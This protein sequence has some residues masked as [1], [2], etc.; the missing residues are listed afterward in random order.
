[1][2]DIGSQL[3]S[4]WARYGPE[5]KINVTDDFTR[6]TLDSIA[7]YASYFMQIIPHIHSANKVGQQMFYGYQVQLV[8]PRRFASICCG[9]AGILICTCYCPRSISNLIYQFFL[10]E[11]G[12][13]AQRP[14]FVSDYLY[15]QSTKKYW[16]SIDLMKSVA[17]SVIKERRAHPT[18]KKDLVNAMILGEDPKTGKT[19]PDNNII[20][21]MITFLIAGGLDI[22]L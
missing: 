13:R 12:A 5:Y 20:N 21:N 15:K 4:K 16:E 19:L 17:A 14:T 6:L 3:V 18:P 7:L 2:L 1:M 10:L 9:Y 22:L 8:L 11:S